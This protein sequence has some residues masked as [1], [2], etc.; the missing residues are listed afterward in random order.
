M[1]G[2][3][4]LLMSHQAEILRKFHFPFAILHFSFAIATRRAVPA[5][6][7]KKCNMANGK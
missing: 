7:N 3:V 6:T 2:F 5:M 4:S 1:Q